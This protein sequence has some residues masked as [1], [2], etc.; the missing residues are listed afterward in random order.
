MSIATELK[1]EDLLVRVKRLEEELA[2]LK[3]TLRE[4]IKSAEKLNGR[5]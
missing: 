2:A 5:R 1:V 3:A 4:A